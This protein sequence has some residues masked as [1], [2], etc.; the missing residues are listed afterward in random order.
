MTQPDLNNNGY[1]SP[2]KIFPSELT[3]QMS[4]K[5]S[6]SNGLNDH[7]GATTIEVMNINDISSS[8]TV[9]SSTLN[10]HQLNKPKSPG[11]ENLS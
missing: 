3:S 9:K 6:G 7:P 4:F 5:I 8:R 11:I 10:R 1:R 2:R